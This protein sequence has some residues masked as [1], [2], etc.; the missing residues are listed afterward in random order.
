MNLSKVGLSIGKWTKRLIKGS[1]IH[2]PWLIATQLT[3][4]TQPQ[5]AE[6]MPNW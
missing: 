3:D 1:G 6:Q 5:E 4:E 2:G